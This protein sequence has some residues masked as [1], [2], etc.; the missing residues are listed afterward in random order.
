M[1]RYLSIGTFRKLCLLSLVGRMSSMTSINALASIFDSLSAEFI[2]LIVDPA[3]FPKSV[4]KRNLRS[5]TG[6]IR[7]IEDFFHPRSAKPTSRF[8]RRPA[9]TGR[10]RIA[11]RVPSA[12]AVPIISSARRSGGRLLSAVH[13]FF[14]REGYWSQ[15]FHKVCGDFQPDILEN[16]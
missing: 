1:E 9:F 5:P 4:S 10:V 8:V 16:I 6:E 7:T 14:I 11:A 13:I 3:K 15:D 12:I 2:R